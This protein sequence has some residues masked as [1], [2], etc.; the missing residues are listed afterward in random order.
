[1]G[2]QP[3][4]EFLGILGEFILVGG[5]LGLPRIQVDGDEIKQVPLRRIHGR[6]Q[7]FIPR[8]PDGGGRQALVD[9]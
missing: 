1:M 2:F 4:L 5:E 8:A 9:A 7:G 3:I 6:F